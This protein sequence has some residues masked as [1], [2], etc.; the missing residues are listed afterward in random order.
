MDAIETITGFAISKFFL[1]GVIVVAALALMPLRRSRSTGW[2]LLLTGASQLTT[3]LLAGVLKNVFE[4]P[5]PFEAVASGEWHGAFFTH[6]SSFPSGHA[7]HFWPLFFAAAVAFPRW[8]WPLLVLAVFVSAARVAVNDHYLA[9]VLAS[10]A[11]AAL[12]TAAY[13]RVLVPLAERART[14][15]IPQ[16]STAAAS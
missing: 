14:V 2:L 10:A 11:I 4:R 9:D 15:A 16:A 5:R 13:A 7:A 8:R 6:G 12:V 1:G 3:R